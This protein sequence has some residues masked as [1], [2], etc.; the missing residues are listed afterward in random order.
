MTAA[1]V[2]QRL[3]AAA[4]KLNAMTN[5]MPISVSVQNVCSSSAGVWSRISVRVSKF[6]GRDLPDCTAACSQRSRGQ[7]AW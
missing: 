6:P 5:L 2:V 7:Y 3:P 1:I 4:H